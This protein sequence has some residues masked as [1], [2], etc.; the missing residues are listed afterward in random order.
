MKFIA[1][2]YQSKKYTRMNLEQ[3]DE[4][5]FIEEKHGEELREDARLLLASQ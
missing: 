1:S 4:Y 3:K 5:T 2:M